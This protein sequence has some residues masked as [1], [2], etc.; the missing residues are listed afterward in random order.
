MLSLFALPVLAALIPDS[1]VLPVLS[2]VYVYQSAF[3][4]LDPAVL[5]LLLLIKAFIL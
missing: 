1:Q 2:V 4:A 3:F 5:L